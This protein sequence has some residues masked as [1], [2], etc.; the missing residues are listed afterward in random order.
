MTLRELR[1]SKG[2]TQVELAAAA[3]CEQT[4]ISQLELGKVG[5]PRYSTVEALAGVL[6]V[7]PAVVAAAIREAVAA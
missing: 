1:E 7:T 4:T 3:G 5:D 6:D 2:L